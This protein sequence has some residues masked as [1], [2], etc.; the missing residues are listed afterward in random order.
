M[1]SCVQFREGPVASAGS[2][3]SAAGC[4]P[5]PCLARPW[6]RQPGLQRCP[7]YAA[8]RE[9]R[10][11]STGESKEL[12]HIH[13]VSP[14]HVSPNQPVCLHIS[15]FIQK[16]NLYIRCFTVCIMLPCQA[17]MVVKLCSQLIVGLLF[18]I[19]TNKHDIQSSAC[20]LVSPGLFS[21]SLVLLLSKNVH[22][23]C[24]QFQFCSLN[25]QRL[26]LACFPPFMH[27][28]VAV[29]CLLPGASFSAFPVCKQLSVSAPVSSGNL[30]RTI[31][32]HQQVGF[33]SRY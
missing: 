10:S 30:P 1:N 17:V 32:T 27:L 16:L 23:R 3:T 12:L 14:P 19:T 15:V 5:A 8:T 7:E 2:H 25:S 29:S 20:Q 33:R 4:Q 31:P 13:V 9:G 6:E 21:A 22:F 24:E 28:P 18:I 11:A 26:L